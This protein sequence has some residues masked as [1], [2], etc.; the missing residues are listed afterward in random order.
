MSH[1][2]HLFAVPGED[3]FAKRQADKKKRV[4]KQ[5]NNRLQNLKKAAK[6]GHLPRYTL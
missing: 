6:V 4:E 1:A 3:P 2:H 5:D